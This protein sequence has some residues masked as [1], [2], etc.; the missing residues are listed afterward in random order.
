MPFHNIYRLTWVS[1]T[2]DI[3]Y[4]FKA[5]P[6][7]CSRCSPD[8]ECGVAPLSPPVPSSSSSLEVGLLLSAAAPDLRLVV[9]LLGRRP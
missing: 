1:L 7:K 2:L 9:A 5:A 4:L 6:A 3:G 8:L